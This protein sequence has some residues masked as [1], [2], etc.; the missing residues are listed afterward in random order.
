M[1]MEL[2]YRTLQRPEDVLKAG[3]ADLRTKTVAGV[4]TRVLSVAQGKTGRTVDIVITPELDNALQMLAG[5]AVAKFS[6]YLVHGLKGRRYTVDGIGSMLRRHCEGGGVRT[7]GLMDLRAKGATDMY[8]RGV[9][10]ES[11]QALM[12][13]ASVRTT[14]IYVKRMMQT[15]R[16]AAPNDVAVGAGK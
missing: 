3:P 12:R 16:I 13:H 2:V 11:I 14:E 7:F 1:A 15:I 5:G 4:A 10:L 8:L 9:P 6:R